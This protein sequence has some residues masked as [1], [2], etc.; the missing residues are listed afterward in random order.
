MQ[1]N[2]RKRNGMRKKL[3]ALNFNQ[4][5][6]D[7]VNRNSVF[8]EK[9][10]NVENFKP[11]GSKQKKLNKKMGS[12]KTVI[13]PPSNPQASSNQQGTVKKLKNKTEFLKTNKE[14]LYRN[15]KE[16]IFQLINTAGKMNNLQIYDIEFNSNLLRVYINRETNPVDLNLC[17]KFMKSL[18]FLFE[19]E[20]VTNM[21]CEVSS[22]GLERF[23]KKDWH[24]VSAIGETVKIH[25]SQP[26]ICYDK[27]IAKKRKKT[28]LYGQLCKFENNMISV[29]DGF[30]NWTIPINIITKARTV[31]NGP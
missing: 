14:N 9:T 28:I 20:G 18:L 7:K 31:F 23:L 17:G 8:D 22:P 15:Q 12:L 29:N 3:S 19:S 2:N 26:V 27:K 4:I 30:L 1:K 6:N 11:I 21:E 25:T 16:K 13:F 24:F 5:E 10:I